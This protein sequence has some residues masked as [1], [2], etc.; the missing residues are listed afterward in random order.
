M[1]KPPQQMPPV[2]L[3][4]ASV[5]GGVLLA[6]AVHI[7][8]SRLGFGLA[9]AWHEALAA[10]GDQFRS[11]LAW[12]LIAA[13]GGLGSFIAAVLLTAPPARTRTRT[14]VQWSVLGAFLVLL[15]GAEH[16]GT[17]DVGIPTKIK[18]LAGLVALGLGAGMA[19][20]GTYFAVRR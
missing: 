15:V 2:L 7:I 3:F 10:S 11:A 12:W 16:Y 6:L 9:S 1:Q 17:G 8:T 18:L 13:A 5:T 20:F 4:A 14:A 19:F